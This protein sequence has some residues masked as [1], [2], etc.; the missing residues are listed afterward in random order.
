MQYQFLTLIIDHAF[1]KRCK[2]LAKAQ[3]TDP[4]WH[5][6]QL[7]VT[8]NGKMYGDGGITWVVIQPLQLG[9]I[10]EVPPAVVLNTANAYITGATYK[11]TSNV[12]FDACSATTT[13]SGVIQHTL[14][15]YHAC[16]SEELGVGNRG[17]EV[18]GLQR[19]R[20][21]KWREKWEEGCTEWPS[22]VIKAFADLVLV[23]YNFGSIAVLSLKVAFNLNCKFSPC[24]F[25]DI[26][27]TLGVANF[28]P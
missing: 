11:T 2:Q 19:S 24:G 15:T 21:W 13:D 20:L 3:T 12:V 18:E 9:G 4:L 5:A 10:A 27:T 1:E 16:W 6:Y 8:R 22:R 14:R 17:F 25:L 26:H 28:G 23:G 7:D